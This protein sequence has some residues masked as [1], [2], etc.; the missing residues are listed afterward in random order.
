LTARPRRPMH[1]RWSEWVAA[2]ES[3]A[4]LSALPLKIRTRH[5]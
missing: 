1:P 2:I 4:E 3:T 5:L